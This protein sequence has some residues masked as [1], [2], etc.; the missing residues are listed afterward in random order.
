MRIS[1]D[2]D[3][4]LDREDVQSC[5]KRMIEAGHEVYILTAR[6]ADPSDTNG[7]GTD[8][9]DDLKRV[10]AEVGIP[11]ERWLFSGDG[12]KGILAERHSIAVHIDDDSGWVTDVRA[13]AMCVWFT[14]GRAE[15][16]LQEFTTL[17]NP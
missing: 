16:C 11:S 8:W 10:A 7:W 6:Y 9:N 4:V 15:R 17:I 1:F 5:A 14:A 2:F 12:T 3:G 13:H